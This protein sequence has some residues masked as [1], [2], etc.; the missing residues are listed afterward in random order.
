MI[1]ALSKESQPNGTA[2]GDRLLNFLLA[3]S[4]KFA[5]LLFL[6]LI[7][8]VFFKGLAQAATSAVTA[9]ETFTLALAREPRAG[10]LWHALMR[11]ADGQPPLFYLLERL[12]LRVSTNPQV[13]LRLPSIL[14]FCCVLTCVF[15]FVKKRASPGQALMCSLLLLNSSLYLIFAGQARPYGLVAAGVAFAMVCYQRV[16]KPLWTVLLFFSLAL[17]VSLHYYAIFALGAFITGEAIYCWATRKARIGV[18]AA[19]FAGALP[20]ILCW[21]ILNAQKQIFAQHFWAQPTLSSVLLSYSTFFLLPA[22]LGLGFVVVLGIALITAEQWSFFRKRET[23]V[24]PDCTAHETALILTM[25]LTPIVLAAVAFIAHGAFLD[26]YVIWVTVGIVVGVGYLL[27]R[28]SGTAL[29]AMALFL[30]IV[31][32]GQEVRSLHLLQLQAR[33]APEAPDA[34]LQRLLHSAGHENLP[35]LLWSAY[36][37]ICYYASHGTA[38]R[39][40]TIT[41]IAGAV[42]YLGT[43]TLE[44]L[45]SAMGSYGSCR[46][47]EFGTFAAAHEEFLLYSTDFSVRQGTTGF[48]DWWIFKLLQ[49]RYKLE[50]VAAEGNAR[51][52][53]VRA[54]QR[55][56]SAGL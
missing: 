21:P 2:F 30:A 4:E 1:E 46:V 43:D 29:A 8:Y 7:A 13:T 40:V 42:D 3:T 50:L 53:L 52:Y 16:A 25:L 27:P 32:S 33:Q 47:F 5:P 20:L 45:A 12:F 37:D 31:T 44:K 34:R 51:L 11:G 48:Y 54:P 55:R 15:F 39:L 18:W 19:I 41:D 17:T 6:T 23:V 49:D 10:A 28:L 35:V 38:E 56:V 26:R 9:D 22:F 36:F 14:A 24:E